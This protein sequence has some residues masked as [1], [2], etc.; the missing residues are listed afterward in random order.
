MDQNTRVSPKFP[1]AEKSGSGSGTAPLQTSRSPEAS[2]MPEPATCCTWRSPWKHPAVDRH[3]SFV[4][5][6][7]SILLLPNRAHAQI[8][9][10]ISDICPTRVAAHGIVIVTSV[11]KHQAPTVPKAMMDRLD[12]ST[13][14]RGARLP[15][16]RSSLSDWLNDKGPIDAGHHAEIDRHIGYCEGSATSHQAPDATMRSRKRRAMPLVLSSTP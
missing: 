11:Q 12:L 3:H 2:R 16:H 7:A 10:W 1:P 14:P 8:N 15:G 4:A 13:P 5:F 6:L 9:D